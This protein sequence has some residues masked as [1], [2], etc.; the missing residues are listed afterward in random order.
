MAQRVSVTLID[1]LDGRDGAR[2]VSFAYDGVEYEIDLVEENIDNLKRALEPYTRRARAAKSTPTRGESKPK[3]RAR[4]KGT[5]TTAV[6][7][8]ARAQGLTVSD[9]GR[10]PASVM[11]RYEEATRS[12]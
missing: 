11:A 6:R 10:I 1:D 3:T 7:E 12:A 9:R 5:D 4:A 2:T 8:W